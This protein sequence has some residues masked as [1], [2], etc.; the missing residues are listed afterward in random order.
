MSIP[1]RCLESPF[2]QVDFMFYIAHILNQIILKHS[3]PKF[4][5]IFSVV[6]LIQ[7]DRDVLS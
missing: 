5:R 4:V 7:V 2:L 3:L 6:S 1:L